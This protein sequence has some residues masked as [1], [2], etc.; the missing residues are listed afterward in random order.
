MDYYA[1]VTPEFIKRPI[2][3]DLQIFT[4]NAPPAEALP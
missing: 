1:L 4:G 3:D 2:Y